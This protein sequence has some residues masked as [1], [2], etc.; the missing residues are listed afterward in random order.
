MCGSCS[1]RRG[2]KDRSCPQCGHDTVYIRI[3]IKGIRHTFWY[4]S[5]GRPLSHSEGLQ[6]LYKINQDSDFNPSEYKKATIKEALFENYITCWLTE[7]ESEIAKGEFAPG[8]FHVYRSY[9][10]N[11]FLPYFA[12]K[13]VREIDEFEIKRF[14]KQ[15]PDSISSHYR[16]NIYLALKT[17]FGWLWESGEITAPV[18]FQKPPKSISRKLKPLSYQDQQDAIDRIPTEHQDLYR[19]CSEAALRMGEACAMPVGDI[20]STR[21]RAFVQWAYSHNKLRNITKGRNPREAVLSDIALEIAQR[22]MKDKLPG[23]FLFT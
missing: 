8:T 6:L 7:K 21:G 1:S 5:H 20:D 23:A 15:L 16:S 4:N 13:S 12:G 22:N 14:R 18:K 11:Y 9:T 19:F 10:K 17:F 3:K 2:E